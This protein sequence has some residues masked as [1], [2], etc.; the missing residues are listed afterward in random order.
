MTV[1]VGQVAKLLLLTGLIGTAALSSAQ[2]PGKWAFDNAVIGPDSPIEVPIGGT[3]QARVFYVNPDSPLIPLDAPVV[4][5]IGPVKGLAIDATG[6]ITVSADVAGGTTA[7]VHANVANGRRKLSAK[8]VVFKS[9][10]LPLTGEWKVQSS[11]L[12]DQGKNVALQH[13]SPHVGDRWGFRVD[14]SV[15]VGVPFGIAATTRWSGTYEHNVATGQIKF[16]RKWIGVADTQEWKA[17][18]VSD[19]EVKLSIVQPSAPADNVCAYVLARAAPV[20]NPLVH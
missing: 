8:V 14:K 18:M 7:T 10:D 13:N 17:E 12:C 5:S 9:A 19:H 15:W 4:W 3:Y 20:K 2:K 1:G 6:K 11:V 16:A